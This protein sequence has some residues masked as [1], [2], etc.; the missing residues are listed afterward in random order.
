MPRV[1]RSGAGPIGCITVRRHIGGADE[2]PQP[3]PSPA[4]EVTEGPSV[5]VIQRDAQHS[6]PADGR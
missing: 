5:V 6:G 2:S 3:E 4:S 1:V